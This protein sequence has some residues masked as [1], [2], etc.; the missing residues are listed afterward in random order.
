MK[1]FF[2]LN[3][4]ALFT[5]IEKDLCEEILKEKIV[6]PK[7]STINNI[8]NYSKALSIRGSSTVGH[9]EMVLN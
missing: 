9:L 6:R 5:L 2:T 4:N 1:K 8:L 3:E 7:K